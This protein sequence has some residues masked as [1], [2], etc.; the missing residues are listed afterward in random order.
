VSEYEVGGGQH[1]QSP[2]NQDIVDALTLEG[3]G[4]V[5]TGVL[6]FRVCE[7]MGVDTTGITS[8]YTL[9]HHENWSFSGFLTRL[10]QMTA[11]GVLVANTRQQ[12]HDLSAG[13]L[14]P[15]IGNGTATAYALTSAAVLERG[16]ASAPDWETALKAGMARLLREQK[17]L[18]QRYARE[19]LDAHGVS[20]GAAARGA[21]RL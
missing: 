18:V 7:V 16:D 14:F 4:P 8:P 12:W 17:P 1:K 10:R 2:T 3:G 13:R 20:G 6:A 9:R 21:D 5:Q 15:E 19:W 11:S